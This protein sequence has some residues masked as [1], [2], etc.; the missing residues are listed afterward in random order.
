MVL[1]IEE[2]RGEEMAG[3]RANKTKLIAVVRNISQQIQDSGVSEE[4]QQQQERGGGGGGK[5]LST[6]RVQ[7]LSKW[8]FLGFRH[9]IGL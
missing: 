2:R 6:I 8:V 4:E 1:E 5:T 9:S 3:Y 7:I